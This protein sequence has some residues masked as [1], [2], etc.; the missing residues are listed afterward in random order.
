LIRLLQRGA[1]LWF[2]RSIF[3]ERLTQRDTFQ[4][5]TKYSL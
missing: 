2:W 1:S 4:N 5:E 3:I